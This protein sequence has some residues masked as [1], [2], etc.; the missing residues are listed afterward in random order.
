MLNI[1]NIFIKIFI[2]FKK[3]FSN[4]YTPDDQE[5]RVLSYLERDK[6]GRVRVHLF[7]LAP[8]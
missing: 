7:Y 2:F 5:E 4:I 3:F 6:K 1:I 8:M